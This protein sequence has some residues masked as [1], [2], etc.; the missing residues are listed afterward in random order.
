[1][2]DQGEVDVQGLAKEID[3]LLIKNSNAKLFLRRALRKGGL[4]KELEQ[5]I[6]IWLKNNF[7]SKDILR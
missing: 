4:P 7:D 1:M 5:D 2:N 3:E 6:D